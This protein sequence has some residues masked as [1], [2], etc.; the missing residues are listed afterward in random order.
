MVL[1]IKNIDNGNYVI[2]L[3]TVN[4]MFPGFYLFA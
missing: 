1:G 2:I 4:M 3:G